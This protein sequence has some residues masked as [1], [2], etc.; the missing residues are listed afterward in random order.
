MV[1]KINPSVC[2]GTVRLSYTIKYS[3]SKCVV[4][5]QTDRAVI[6]SRS[7]VEQSKSK[8]T[9]NESPIVMPHPTFILC[10]V[11]LNFEDASLNK[12]LAPLEDD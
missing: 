10:R 2:I 3:P 12:I 8:F 4:H 7:K 1:A 6:R 11:E 9:F 5:F